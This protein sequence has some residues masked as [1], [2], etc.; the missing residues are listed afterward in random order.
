MFCKLIVPTLQFAEPA[1]NCRQHRLD[2]EL[3]KA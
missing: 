1:E 2:V 3:V